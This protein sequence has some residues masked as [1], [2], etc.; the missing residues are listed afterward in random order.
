[1][2]ICEKCGSA[3]PN[4]MEIDG[5]TRRLDA[6]KEC[7]TCKPL[8]PCREHRTPAR[9]AVPPNKPR[10]CKYHACSNIINKGRSLFCHYR[11]ENK[12]YVTRHRAKKQGYL[13]D[14][15]PEIVAM[16]LAS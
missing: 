12:F 2:P 7:P 1:M 10:K 9:M 5:R 13:R 14:T 15:D 3:F 6:R 16:Y 11:C 4:R 8:V